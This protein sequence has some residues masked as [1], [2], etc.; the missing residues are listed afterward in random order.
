MLWTFPH[1]PWC[2]LWPRR[3]LWHPLPKPHTFRSLPRHTQPLFGTMTPNSVVE[4]CASCLSLVLDIVNWSLSQKHRP[5]ERPDPAI[6]VGPALP[7]T[8]HS[9]GEG[10]EHITP[11]ISPDPKA[12][13]PPATRETL[14]NPI[15]PSSLQDILLQGLHKAKP[16]P[17]PVLEPSRGRDG[18][19]W[20]LF[21]EPTAQHSAHVSA[22]LLSQAAERF[23]G[24]LCLWNLPVPSSERRRHTRV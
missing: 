22:W 13:S 21:T 7:G 15:T 4:S 19:W 5:W 11:G 20:T 2:S 6:Q 23:T 3:L 16:H 14:L 12:S 18:S 1:Q 17:E 8:R 10:S 9:Q 24:S